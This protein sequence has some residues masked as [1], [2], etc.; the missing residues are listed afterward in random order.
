MYGTMP[1]D[2]HVNHQEAAK[3]I[4]LRVTPEEHALIAEAAAQANQS[5]ASW[6]L[7]H[8]LLG[9]RDWQEDDEPEEEGTC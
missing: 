8:L 1:K 7:D 9:A 3:V 6:C 5:I 4:Y 2:H